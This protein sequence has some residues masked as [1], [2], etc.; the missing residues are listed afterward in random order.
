M[1]VYEFQREKRIQEV[2]G[3]IK[4]MSIAGE[5]MDKRKLILAISNRFNISKK[6]AGEYLGVAIYRNE[7]N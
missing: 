4:E 2:A 7:L 5:P 6:T 1:R 3:L